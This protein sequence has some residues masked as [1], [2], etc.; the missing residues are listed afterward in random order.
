MCRRGVCEETRSYH[1]GYDYLI[2]EEAGTSISDI[3]AERG[4]ETFRRMETELLKK[5]VAERGKE[6]ERLILSV[7]GGLPMRKE[8]R[9]L[10]KKL[11]RV[12]YLRV[13]AD[14]VLKRLK[15]DT[16]RP[17]LQGD[18]VR[19]KVEEL[20]EK[21]NPIYMESSHQSV[22]VDGIDISHVV[23][24]IEKLEKDTPVYEGS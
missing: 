21:R 17:L 22:E 2:R 7:G 12:V 9:E 24:M 18:N 11:G 10:L 14:T 16:S 3:F 19:Q 23:K 20:I 5:L 1:G 15:G 6:E 8:N 13:S 4:E